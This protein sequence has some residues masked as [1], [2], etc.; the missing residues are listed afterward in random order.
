MRKLLALLALF[1]TAPAMAQQVSQFPT[2]NQS[3]LITTGNT[4]QTISSGTQAM[5]SLTIQNN[6][7]NTDNCWIEVSGIVTAG[8]TTSSA[9]TI[10]GKPAS[11]A[12]KVSMVLGPGVS[13]GRY[14]VHAPTGP[15]VGTCAT[16]GDSLYVDW[17]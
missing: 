14:Q 13:Y 7:T 17:Q 10:T 15:I 11:T 4:F 6:N 12:A 1:F 9:V 8:M 16:T 2:F 5:R 3:I